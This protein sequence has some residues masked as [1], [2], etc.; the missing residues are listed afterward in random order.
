MHI[1]VSLKHATATQIAL[2][3]F[4]TLATA[5]ASLAQSTRTLTLILRLVPADFGV[6]MLQQEA[7]PPG[8]VRQI[9]NV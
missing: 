3:S 4:V 7:A 9:R 5:F 1:F 6:I 2:R 8:R